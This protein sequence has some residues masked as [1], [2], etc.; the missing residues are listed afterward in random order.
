MTA[1]INTYLVVNQDVEH[2][3]FHLNHSY[4]LTS[5]GISEPKENGEF[6]R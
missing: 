4:S 5:A 1:V 2:N 3:S 6:A